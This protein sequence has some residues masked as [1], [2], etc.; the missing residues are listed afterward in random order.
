MSKQKASRRP[1]NQVLT[2]LSSADFALLQPNLVEVALTL[3]LELEPANKPIKHIYFPLSG[4]GSVV[5]Q[6]SSRLQIEAGIFGW[7]G[8]SGLPV[9]M[10]DTRSPHQVYVQVAGKG[11]GLPTSDLRKAM[12]QSATLQN[13]LLH[14]AHAFMIQTAHTALANGR[15]TID[16]RLARWIL[17]AHDR[18]MGD[19]IPLTHDFLALMLGVRRSGVTIALRGL[20]RQALINTTRGAI[21]VQDRKGLE[22][23]AGGIYGSAEAEYR[24]LIGWQPR[25]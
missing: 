8:M 22:N 12:A 10:G 5:A 4:I 3:R 16:K 18:L 15:A 20:E 13:S 6:S 17:M 21:I 25:A 19:H 2:S 1:H 9:V 23:T 14:F 7:E 24:R 11:L